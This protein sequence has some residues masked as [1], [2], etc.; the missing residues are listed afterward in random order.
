MMNTIELREN[1][2]RNIDL[3]DNKLLKMLKALIETYKDEEQDWWFT[4]S[5]QEQEEIREGLRQYETGDVVS[6]EEAMKIFDKWK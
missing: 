3:A 2:H 6:H 4:L 5:E 1:L